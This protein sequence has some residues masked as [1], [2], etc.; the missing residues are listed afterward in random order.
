MKRFTPFIALAA[1]GIAVAS[2]QDADP[3]APA[4]VAPLFHASGSA[5]RSKAPVL[6][7]SDG[8][9]VGSSLL[10]RNEGGV[11]VRLRTTGWDPGTAL[12]LWIVIF[13]DPSACATSPCGEPDLFVP[14][15]QADVLYTA[16]HVVG[17]SGETTFAGRRKVGDT[18]G[19]L[20]AI[21]TGGPTPGLLDA[22]TAEIHLIVRTHGPVIPELMPD[23]IRTF[24]G[25]CLGVPETGELGA[26]GPNECAD[27]Q[28]A[29]HQP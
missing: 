1:A 7:F 25:G 13:N 22:R 15:V 29:I 20:F 16:G 19:S 11:A 27:L 18:S 21:L 5:A 28:F 14:E 8:A 6:T 24:G 4:D 2:C 26:P 12:T 23:M 17:G 9:E 3:T 10:V